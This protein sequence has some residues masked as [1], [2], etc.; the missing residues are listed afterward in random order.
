M[1]GLMEDLETYEKNLEKKIK[2]VLYYIKLIK[3]ADLDYT[4]IWANKCADRKE[5]KSKRDGTLW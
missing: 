4:T 2:T 5:W 1:L 3:E